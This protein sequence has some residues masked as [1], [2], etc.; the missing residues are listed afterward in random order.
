MKRHTDKEREINSL[1]NVVLFD[2]SSETTIIITNNGFAFL[3]RI[4]AIHIQ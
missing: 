3:G 4:L 2:I 1:Q